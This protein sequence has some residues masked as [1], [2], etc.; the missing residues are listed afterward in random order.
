MVVNDGEICG[1]ERIKGA[2]CHTGG[3]DLTVYARLENTWRK[4]LTGRRDRRSSPT[5]P[6]MY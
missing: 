6:K 5:G 1:G 4:V 2:N 3:C